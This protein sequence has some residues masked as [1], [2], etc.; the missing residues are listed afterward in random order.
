MARTG[1]ELPGGA[2]LTDYISLGAISER[3]PQIE[4]RRVLEETGRESERRRKLP[5]HVMVYYVV[6]LALFME[7]SYG[8]V[9]R[10]LLEGLEWL[11]LPVKAIGT[12]SKSSISRARTRLGAE[13]LRKLYEELVGPIATPETRG[14]WYAGRRL[15]SLDG[16]T[17]DVPDLPRNEAA[18]GRP[19]ASRGRSGFPQLRFV[20]LLECGTHVLFGAGQGPY[21]SSE[22]ELARAGR[23]RVRARARHAVPGGP[24]VL[25]LR[26]VE[27][28]RLHRGRPAL[29][30]PEE[31][32]VSL[33]G[34]AARRL[35]PQPDLPLAPGDRKQDRHG[36]PVRVIEYR[37]EGLEDAGPRFARCPLYR[38]VTTLLEPE[39]APA[40]ELAALYHE[41]W[42]I[43]TAFDELKVHLRGPRVVLRSRTPELVA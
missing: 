40:A 2:R 15:V 29:A 19:G 20:S 39:E 43:E 36:L 17:L 32:G 41:R 6:A 11:G 25:R 8:E 7:V 4:V 31:P 26:A 12:V 34:A 23:G 16:A 42:E 18:F 30:D 14:A 5:M 33:H 28:G 37:L 38:L 24:P 27:A 13:P 9:L 21:A 35:V 22:T 10:C 1:A 3:I